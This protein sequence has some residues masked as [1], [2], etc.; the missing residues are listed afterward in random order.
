MC[1]VFIYTRTRSRTKWPL[2]LSYARQKRRRRCQQIGKLV[3]ARMPVQADIFYCILHL[4][5]TL[6]AIQRW[7]R[8]KLGFNPERENHSKQ[9][10][11]PRVPTR[12]A[13]I[14]IR[15]VTSPYGPQKT[16][17][18]PWLRHSLPKMALV[19]WSP[20][21]LKPPKVSSWL[22]TTLA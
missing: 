18:R 5:L 15:E 8:G 19:A 9:Q 16:Q 22:S 21:R 12:G 14:L 3:T 1:E 13:T 2:D 7:S 11:L 20:S 10:K 6:F 17:I 4:H